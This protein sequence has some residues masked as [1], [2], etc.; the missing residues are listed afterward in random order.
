M[1]AWDAV[2]RSRK[3]RRCDRCGWTIPVGYQYLYSVISPDHDDVGNTTWWRSA[4]CA[5]CAQANEQ[6]PTPT[7]SSVAPVSRLRCVLDADHGGLHQNGAGG[8]N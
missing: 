4:T 2:R 6:W 8:W 5:P 1:A 3:P 7:C